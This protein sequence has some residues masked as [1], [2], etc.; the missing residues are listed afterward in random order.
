MKTQ[1]RRILVAIVAAI[2]VVSIVL[3]LRHPKLVL[4]GLV[5][6]DEVIVGSQ[7]D[8]RISELKVE[9]GQRVKK[10]DLLAVIAPEEMRADFAY[11]KNLADGARAQASQALTELAFEKEQAAQQVKQAEANLASAEAQVAQA[12]ADL[13]MGRINLDRAKTLRESG[14]NSQQDLDVARTSY[15]SALARENS[16]VKQSAAAQAA[17]ALARTGE[18]Q[19][20]ERQS[21]LEASQSQRDAA[22]EQARKA[23]IVLGYTELKAPVDGIVN[24]RAALQGEVVAPGSAV[25]TLINPADLWVRADVEETYI[26]RIHLGDTLTVRLP[27]GATREGKVFYR[28]VD[29]DYAT[30]R[31]VSRTKR[32][33]RTFEV[34]IRCDNS[35]ESLAVG[36]TAFVV[37]PFSG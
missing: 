37:L 13:E 27:S 17:V 12:R 1:R 35:D 3:G 21:A 8:G 11:A 32:D 14:T 34:R 31:D 10:G 19:V 2:L 5:T 15:D 22:I 23:E 28:G 25:V 26:D 16:V 4:T 6:T 24:V 18:L 29:A 30:Q 36:M 20:A 9:Q 33:I 7:I